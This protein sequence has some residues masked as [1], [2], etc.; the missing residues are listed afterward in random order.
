[1]LEHAEMFHDGEARGLERR[2]EIPCRPGPVAQEI[3]DAAAARVG[4]RLPDR[5]E[6][7]AICDTVTYSRARCQPVNR[8]R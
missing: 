1:M 2:A 7:P 6:V 8:S 5:V 3:Q 4:E